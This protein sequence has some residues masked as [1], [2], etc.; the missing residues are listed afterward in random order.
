MHRSHYCNRKVQKSASALHFAWGIHSFIVQLHQNL[1][2]LKL[3]VSLLFLLATTVLLDWYREWKKRNVMYWFFESY[4]WSLSAYYNKSSASEDH[5]LLF[6]PFTTQR[7]CCTLCNEG[8]DQSS[9]FCYSSS[10]VIGWFNPPSTGRVWNM[11]WGNSVSGNVF[12]NI[13]STSSEIF[14]LNF[15]FSIVS[16]AVVSF[17]VSS[18]MRMF[19]LNNSLWTSP[20]RPSGVKE[21]KKKSVIQNNLIS[22]DSFPVASLGAVWVFCRC[23]LADLGCSK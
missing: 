10:K 13:L 7:T 21:G 8:S 9:C 3:V 1:L 18:E 4:L 17:I 15:I 20:Q 23:I 2:C 22:V 6:I 14:F 12:I 11:L 16:K 19:T 5:T